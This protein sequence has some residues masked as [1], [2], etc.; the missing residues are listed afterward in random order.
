MESALGSREGHHDACLGAQ[1]SES[2]ELT[3]EPK[4]TQPIEI[5]GAGGENRTSTPLRAPEFE[6]KKSAL[7]QPITPEAV[8]W[9]TYKLAPLW[10]SLAIIG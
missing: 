2:R 7:L 6:C 4:R 9:I 5:Y 10:Y 8:I 3:H 1:R